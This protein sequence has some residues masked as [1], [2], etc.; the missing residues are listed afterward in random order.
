MSGGIEAAGTR[1]CCEPAMT[2]ARGLTFVH[3]AM[4]SATSGA[5]AP[6]SLRVL[7]G[8]IASVGRA[9]EPGDRVVDLGGDRLL[10]GLINAHDHLQLNS[11]PPL[12]LAPGFRNVREWIAAVSERA[13]TDAAFRAI[14][15]APRE[16]RL[17]HGGLKNLLGGVTTVAHHDPLYPALTDARFP[18]RV[19]SRYGWSHSLG[20]DGDAQVCRAFERTPRDWPWIAHAAEGVDDAAAAEFGRLDDLGCIAANTL[21]V[22]GVALGAAERARLADAGGGLVWCPASNLALFGR[23]AT[24]AD[25][26]AR[27]RVALGTD[28]RLSGT[29]D[30][31]QE[32]R[33]AQ[34]VAG[35]DEAS[36]AE[37]VT[38]ASAQL[39]RLTDHGALEPG[40]L[41]DLL[42]LPQSLA[43]SQAE[44]RDVRMVV[45]GGEMRYGDADCAAAVSA[46]SSQVWTEITVDGRRKVLDRALAERLC[47][48]GVVEPG[49]EWL[50]S[51]AWRAA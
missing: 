2:S 47:R 37:L 31:L 4:S 27:G 34:E 43:L 3:A 16:R 14:V 10:P 11:F 1:Y 5:G 20:I 38:S 39:L 40:R 15:D 7:D 51:E 50:D 28:S 29:R 48:E 49:L 33:V 24:V 42:V 36:L 32:L 25:L 8:R 18:V 17:L 6:T 41:A 21:I 19:V 23:S 26:V 22:H 46:T 35:F 44:R 12:D 30:L 13:R 45:I 9:P